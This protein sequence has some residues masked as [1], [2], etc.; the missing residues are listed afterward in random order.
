MGC[1]KVILQQ[2]VPFRKAGFGFVGEGSLLS[3][4]SRWGRVDHRA[5]CAIRGGVAGEGLVWRL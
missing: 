4:G 2:V 3:P 1:A 5:N